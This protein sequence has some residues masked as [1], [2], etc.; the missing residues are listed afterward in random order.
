[1]DGEEGMWVLEGDEVVAVNGV[2]VE[3]KTLDE[4]SRTVI[5]SLREVAPLVKNSE[6]RGH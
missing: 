2:S 5:K 1:M 6:G 4:A 3:G